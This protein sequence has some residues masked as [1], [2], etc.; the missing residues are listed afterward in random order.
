M[1]FSKQLC[2]NYP[3]KNKFEFL[4]LFLLFFVFNLWPLP[5]PWANEP[6]CAEFVSIYCFFDLF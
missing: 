4:E 6:Q 1:S 5:L 2:K 3:T